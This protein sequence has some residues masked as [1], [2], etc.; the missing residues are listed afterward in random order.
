MKF[1]RVLLGVATIGFGAVSSIEA[2]TVINFNTQSGTGIASYTESGVTF[3]ADAIGGT[4]EFA[5]GPNGT[6][7][8]LGFGSPR[9]LIRADISGGASS[10]SVDIGDFNQD[11]DML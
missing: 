5:G 2:A 9:P 8:V 6:V 7:G 10:V 3:T 4:L 11:P 1:V